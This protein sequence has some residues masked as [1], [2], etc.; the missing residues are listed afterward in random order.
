M[1]RFPAGSRQPPSP[2]RDVPEQARGHPDRSPQVIGHA[3]LALHRIGGAPT[4]CHLISALSLGAD[5]VEL[6][7]CAS[8]DDRLLLRHDLWLPDGRLVADVDLAQH[9]RLDPSMLT[10]DE[11]AEQLGGR[12]PMLL[13]LKSARAAELL[14]PWFARRRDL[15]LF[16]VCTENL[17]LLVHLRFAAPR[18]ARWPSFPDLGEHS[19][20]RVQSVVAGLWRTHASLSGLRRGAADLRGAAR[21]LRR[22]PHESLARIGG[23]PWRESLPVDIARPCQDLAAEGICVQQW[24]I[25]DRLVEEAHRWGLHVNTWTINNTSVAP[26][27]AAAGVDSITTDRVAAIRLA[28]GMGW[29][30]ISAAG[31]G[32]HLRVAE[33]TAPS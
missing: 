1:V 3:G 25:S 16:T 31:G 33:R 19:A 29:P 28:L 11:A 17:P 9:R 5:R 22:R 18:V 15:R 27:V 24:L 4:R 10:L 2:A 32:R 23:L 30:P 6:D 12:L 13:D 7:V 26:T 20:H 21:Q 14:G 8:A